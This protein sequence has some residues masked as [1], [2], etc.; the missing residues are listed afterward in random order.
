MKKKEKGF[1]SSVLYKISLEEEG[2][3]DVGCP[4]LLFSPIAL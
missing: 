2:L 4:K 3:E 1:Y